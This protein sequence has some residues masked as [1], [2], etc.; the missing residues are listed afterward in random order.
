ML[1][2]IFKYSIKNILR[3]KFLSFSSVL[4]LT[5]L[6]FFINILF[7]LHDVSF[8]LIDTINSKLTISLYLDSDYDKNSLEVI[9]LIN[10]IKALNISNWE[11]WEIDVL[12][13]TKEDILEDIRIKEPALVKI[14]ER[15]NPLPDTIVLSN[16]KL[17]EYSK[18]N[19]LIENKMFILSKE[20]SDTEYFAN[21]SSQYKKITN[22]IN[23]LN[24]LQY[25]LYL[26]IAIFV[27][28]ISII[29]YSVIWNFIYY[30]KDEIYIT[31][32]VWWS[33]Q[34]I[35]W[36]FVFQGAIYSFLASFISFFVFSLILDY[37]NSSFSNIYF[38]SF[39]FLI[40]VLEIFL[41]VIIWAFA[42]YLSSRKYLK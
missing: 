17:G 32:L 41:F 31:R 7:V 29:I 14:L 22:I 12:Y 42:W 13:K 18:L 9:D 5:L 27:V 3:N 39:S 37:V 8:K 35:Y 25:G 36:P 34:F 21:Y 2:R 24:V 16:I 40:F 10:D 15:S 4:V 30:Y 26:I 1:K 19:T 33:K 6:I 23:I 20:N 38:F 28:S 11:T